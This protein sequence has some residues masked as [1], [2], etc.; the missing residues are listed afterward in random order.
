MIVAL[1]VALVCCS[2][3]TG[4]WIGSRQ[5]AQPPLSLQSFEEIEVVGVVDDERIAELEKQLD[6]ARIASTNARHGL[7]EARAET[8]RW[9]AEADRSTAHANERDAKLRVAERM[10]AVTNDARRVAADAQLQA[11]EQ[12]A[13]LRLQLVEVESQLSAALEAERQRAAA[14]IADLGERL[15]AR[16]AELNLAHRDVDRFSDRC[17]HL[18]EELRQTTELL[19]RAS[20]HAARAREDDPDDVDAIRGAL[21]AAQDDLDIAHREIEAMQRAHQGDIEMLRED[22]STALSELEELRTRV[23]ASSRRKVG[24]GS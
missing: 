20:E 3:A 8:E 15:A 13:H 17:A 14:Q 16:E 11:E 1:L 4:W 7:E 5:P 6:V 9:R 18:E 2:I 10:L 23:F 19:D 21:H 22:L 24:T 12:V